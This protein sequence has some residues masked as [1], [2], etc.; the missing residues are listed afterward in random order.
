MADNNYI[1]TLDGRTFS[2]NNWL[3][4]FDPDNIKK[5]DADGKLHNGPDSI[6]YLT[7]LYSNKDS[8]LC[9]DGTR[10]LTNN[11]I[12]LK[13]N[14]L[15]QRKRIA[16]ERGYP[17]CMKLTSNECAVEYLRVY[18]LYHL[19]YFE[20]VMC[21]KS[22]QR[23]NVCMSTHQNTPFQTSELLQLFEKQLRYVSF[24]FQSMITEPSYIANKT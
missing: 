19:T 8:T 16:F 9:F 12:V 20:Y 6:K 15:Y 10:D 17:S 1:N 21:N 5:I 3:Q 24:P 7:W 22:I 4:A 13:S 2:L 14:S 11:H 23:Y 18:K